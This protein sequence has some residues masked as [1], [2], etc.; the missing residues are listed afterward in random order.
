MGSDDGLVH[1]TKDGGETWNNITPK[2]LEETIINAI[3][4]S[5]HDKGTVYIAT[6]RYKFNDKEPGLYKSTNYGKSWKDISGNIPYGAYT[7]VVREDNVRE[8]L[9]FAGTELGVYVS[10]NGGKE[11]EIF[12]LNMPSLAVTDLMIKH[13]DLIVATQGRSFWILDDMGLIRQ[14]NGSNNTSLFKP[15]NSITGGWYSQLNSNNKEFD[16]TSSYTGVNPANGIVIY[17]NINKEDANKDVRI[18]IKDDK[19][20][21]VREIDNSIDKDYISYNGGP[22][23]PARLTNNVGLNRFVWDLSLI[24]I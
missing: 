13:S 23:R 11:W 2:N 21:L 17:Y 24:H 5:P 10:F 9:L 6:T 16:G 12:N 22:S 19:D 4:I 3:D 18:Q 20:R 1:L 14:Y 15:E 8:D 7:R